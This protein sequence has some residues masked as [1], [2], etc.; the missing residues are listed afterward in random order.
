[1]AA[2]ELVGSLPVDKWFDIASLI[3]LEMI[4]QKIVSNQ[5]IER[6]AEYF[7]ELITVFCLFVGE[8]DIAFGEGKSP[9]PVAIRR[10]LKSKLLPENAS[11]KVAILS[12]LEI[13]IAPD[14]NSKKVRELAAVFSVK[15][16]Y[17]LVLD[18]KAVNRYQSQGVSA[19]EYIKLASSALGG[20]IPKAGLAFI[21]KSLVVQEPVRFLDSG[22]PIM[23]SSDSQADL[24]RAN[25]KGKIT[26]EY[27]NRLFLIESDKF[28]RIE[29]KLKALGIPAVSEF[30]TQAKD[31][32]PSKKIS[33]DDDNEESLMDAYFASR[34]S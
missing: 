18:A 17:T 16:L 8:L 33:E 23:V 28:S 14:L 34:Y 32:K 9:G 1:M 30:K 6:N 11:V 21:E 25:F 29:T 7:T 3:N 20:E 31:K 5:C 15:D 27:L 22:L 4:S 12:N 19:A 13:P 26:S 2:R 10:V 24:I